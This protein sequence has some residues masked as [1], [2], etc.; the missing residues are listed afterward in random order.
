VASTHAQT[1]SRASR[2]GTPIRRAEQRH[3]PGVGSGGPGAIA[4]HLQ[5]TLGN[6]GA[7]ALLQRMIRPSGSEA[8]CGR[9][10]IRSAGTT[11][12]RE[13]TRP[14]AATGTGIVA[15]VTSQTGTQPAGPVTAGSLARQ[16]WE[17]LFRRHFAEPDQIE[18]ELESSHA[19][20]F[21]SRI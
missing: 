21:Y 6:Q 8:V 11:I 12:Q 4:Q 10:H 2:A 16:E 3:I 14:R 18:D 15:D 20:Y 5:R 17:S 19:R 13:A 9:G 1:R 7:Q